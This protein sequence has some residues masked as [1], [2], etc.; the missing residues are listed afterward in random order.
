MPNKTILLLLLLFGFADVSLLW[1]QRGMGMGQ[2]TPDQYNRPYNPSTVETIEG[3]VSEI[4]YIRKNT[5]SRIHGVH[6]VVKTEEGL[7]PVHLGPAWYVERQAPFKAGD[8]V[9]VVGS[10]IT[11][12]DEPAVVAARV[13]RGEMTLQLR[14]QDGFPAWRG[15]RKGRMVN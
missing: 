9:T 14:D 11:F 1:A 4:V 3:E 2:G 8:R 13:T 12:N 15:W 10:R 5:G 7:V 6:L